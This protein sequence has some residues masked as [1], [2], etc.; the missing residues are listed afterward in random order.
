MANSLETRVPFLD[1]DLVDFATKIPVGMKLGNLSKIV[2]LDENE[3]GSKTEKY[4][5]KTKD[6]KLILRNVMEN[7]VPKKYISRNKKGFSAPDSSWFRGE[8]INFVNKKIINNNARIFD[9][10]YRETIH[11]LVGDHIRGK[12]NRRLLIWSLLSLE[13]WLEITDDNKWKIN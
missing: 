2:N 7:Y 9:Y 8:S 10:L 1:N 13:T 4:F 11:S 12:N 6:G 3:S 5:N